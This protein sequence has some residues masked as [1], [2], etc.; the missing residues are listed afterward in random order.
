VDD[1]DKRGKIKRGRKG[2]RGK[3]IKG[4]RRVEGRRK[5]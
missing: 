4:G 2:E 5:W 1:D 3:E